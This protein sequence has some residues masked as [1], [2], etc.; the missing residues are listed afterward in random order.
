MI[1]FMARGRKRATLT[2][3]AQMTE[4]LAGA[5]NEITD[6][7]QASGIETTTE[8]GKI[9]AINAQLAAIQQSLS[10][11]EKATAQRGLAEKT[12][13]LLKAVGGDLTKFNGVLNRALSE[14]KAEDEAPVSPSNV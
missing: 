6:F 2:R 4:E 9:E 5:V 14:V 10:A 3:V 12:V 8:H 13:P 1:G 11:G 7:G